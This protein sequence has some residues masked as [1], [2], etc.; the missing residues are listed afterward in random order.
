MWS[1]KNKTR[2]YYKKKTFP[3]SLVA[4]RSSCSC[5]GASTCAT[6]SAPCPR[7]STSHATWLLPSTMSSSYQPSSTS[8]GGWKKLDVREQARV[9]GGEERDM[10]MW[11]MLSCTD[12]RREQREENVEQTVRETHEPELRVSNNGA[13]YPNFTNT[14]C[15]I[16]ITEIF[17]LSERLS[18]L[19]SMSARPPPS[20]GKWIVSA[21]GRVS[22]LKGGE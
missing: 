1:I 13:S 4:Q 9:W 12:W 18:Q 16:I 6:L 3:V 22:Q 14:P 5:C 11:V 2:V 15:L 8:S 19:Q 7:P 10:V 20:S 17:C 21:D